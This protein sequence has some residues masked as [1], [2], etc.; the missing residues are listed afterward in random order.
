M[1]R[2]AAAES[3]ISECLALVAP[4]ESAFRSRWRFSTLARVDPDL[5]N[6]VE[7]Q[8]TLYDV[9]LLTGSDQECREQAAAMVR[10]WRAACARL[11]QPL[12]SDDAYFVGWDSRTGRKVVIG[13]HPASTARVQPSATQPGLSVTYITPDEVARLVTGLEMLDSVKAYFPDAE[14]ISIEKTPSQQGMQ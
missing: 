7:E 5:A 9:A 10:G 12:Q 8:R 14:L 4:A 2:A 13:D 1:K 11:E 6:L 3:V